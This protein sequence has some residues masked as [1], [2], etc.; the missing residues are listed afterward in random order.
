MKMKLICFFG[1]DSGVML[2]L[3]AVPLYTLPESFRHRGKPSP[4]QR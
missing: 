4:G 3:T 2:E 1:E